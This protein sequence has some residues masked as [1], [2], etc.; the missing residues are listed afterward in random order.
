MKTRKREAFYCCL[1]HNI[2]YVYFRWI[3]KY[4]VQVK[5]IQDI[6][7]YFVFCVVGFL[8]PLHLHK[9]IL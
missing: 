3:T 1:I 6:D 4:C 5:L 2:L 8:D 7:S 9:K